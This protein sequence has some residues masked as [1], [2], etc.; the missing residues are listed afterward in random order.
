MGG[1]AARG[2][3]LYLIVIARFIPGGRTAMT[4]AAGY[5]QGMPWRRFIV[6]DVIAGVIWGDVRGAA[7]LRR[8]QA[9]RGEPPGRG[10]SLAFVVAVGIA[11]TVEGVRSSASPRRSASG[12]CGAGDTSRAEARR[13]LDARHTLSEMNDLAG[14]TSPYLLQHAENPVDWYEWGDRRSSAPEPRTGPSCSRSDTAP[15]TGAM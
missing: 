2:A 8:R 5:T 12:R 9:V 14:A 3:R 13:G 7:R 10:C 1:A 15:A 11:M 4:F 6:A